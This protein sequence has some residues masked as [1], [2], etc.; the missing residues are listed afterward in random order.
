MD[1]EFDLSDAIERLGNAENLDLDHER[2]PSNEDP[3]T[4]LEGAVEAVADQ[5]DAITIPEVFASYCS[6]LKHSGTIPS[7]VMN[8]LLDS[9]S[10]GLQAEFDS[11]YSD[12]S[13][14]NR[15]TFDTHKKALEMYA[16]LLHWAVKVAEKVKGSD[17]DDRIS[18]VVAPKTRR[19]R[20]AKAA[21]SG[22][23]GGRTG[24]KKQTGSEEWNWMGQI[25]QV[26]ALISKLMSRLQTQRLWTTTAE[27]DK[28][29]G[30][31]TRPAYHVAENEQ[32]MKAE[33][34]KL[35]V[36][37]V[38]CLAVKHQGHS[39]AAQI[40]IMQRL[41]YY[42]HLAEPMAHCLSVLSKEFDHNQLGD[43]ILREVSHKDFRGQ[44]QKQTKSFSKFL[45]KIAEVSPRM[46]L[47]QMSLLVNHLDTDVANIRIAM[48]EVIGFLIRDLDASLDAGASEDG[49]MDSKQI[50][51]QIKGLYEMLLERMLDTNAP[52]RSKVLG[53]LT[54]L[55]KMKRKFPKQRL[56]ATKVAIVALEDKMPSVRKAAIVLVIEL[57][58]THPYGFV[59]GGPLELEHFE[60]EYH[61]IKTQLAE[62][63]AK[64][65]NA[66]ANPEDSQDQEDQEE[67]RTQKKRSDDEDEDEMDVDEDEQP[68]DEEKE[69]EDESEGED[70]DQAEEDTSMAGSKP[71]KAKKSKLKPRK[72]QINVVQMSAEAAIAHLEGRIAEQ[73]R[74]QKKFYVE[75]LNFIRQLDAATEIVLKLLGS[76]NKAEVLEGIHFFEV[77]HEYKL[78]YTEEGLRQMM[79]LIWSKD[80]SVTTSEDGTEQLKGIRSRLLECYRNLYFVVHAGEEAQSQ[81]NRIARNMIELTYGAT[82]AE[83]TSLEE[84]IRVMIEDRQI[85]PDVVNKLWQIFGKDRQLPK[86]QRRG[87]IIIIGMMALAKRSVLADRVETMLKVGLGALGKADLTLA[88]YTCVALQRLNGSAKKVKGSLHNKTLRLP[89]DNAVF[90]KLQEVI[91]R[92][93]RSKEWFGV[94]EQAINTIY[95][96]GEHPDRLC[97]DIIK[98]LTF[99]AFTPRN[100]T[101][102]AEQTQA[103]GDPDA[104][105]QDH[106]EDVSQTSDQPP[107]QAGKDDSLGDAFEL[108]QLL[109]VVGHIAIKHIAFLEIVER[110][111]KRQKDEKQAAEKAARG[112]HNTNKD[113]EELDQVAGNAEDEIGDRVQEI[114]EHELLE[115]GSLLALF[116][117]MLVHICGSPH[118]FKN[119]TLRAAATLSLSK[120]LCVSSSFCENNHRLLFKILET[121]KNASIRS[122][123]VIGLGDVA[124]SF[125]SIID[126]NSNELYKGLSDKDPV[127]KKNTLMVLTHLILNGMVKVK[128]Q[129]GE[130]AKCLQDEDPRIADL[131]K[132]FF[133]E[134]STKDNA[135]YNNLPDVISHLSTGEHA[136]DEDRFQSTMK[137]IFTFIEKEK[138][139]E[140]IVDKL[141]QRFRVA[142]E[143]RQWRDI[144][145]CLSLLPYKSE[146]SIKKLI[147]SLPAYQDKLHAEGV[148]DRFSEI[149]AKAR[150]PKVGVSKENGGGVDLQE[151]E[152][153][154]EQHKRQ[155]EDDQALEKRVEKKK[156][157]AKKRASRRNVRSKPAKVEE[158]DD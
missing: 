24:T 20:G 74:L 84:M 148:Y 63:E 82:L 117:P 156:A 103:N 86:Q 79:H 155:G 77:A 22:R 49:N 118:K 109:F 129:L 125:N 151:F 141:C 75:A 37:K 29:I 33:D 58:K 2:D 119:P 138:Q 149:L 55:C 12:I 78:T 87:A 21:G 126:E 123:V 81:V 83:L 14:D 6:L 139:A 47:K 61:S 142:D 116:G 76:T 41:Q 111:W 31:I 96:L 100:R 52:V 64:V 88:R 27:R 3:E 66:L 32:Y 53:V 150:Q 93:C 73:L 19:G 1:T 91:E 124:V 56:E 101:S 133:T 26:L 108:S 10:S 104:M 107:S 97:N 154:L 45:A 35:G 92:P 106:P 80:N 40:L 30:C 39:A 68:T 114:R 146:K 36:Y 102:G 70:D 90:R 136:V 122:N 145:F 144:A 85:H 28:F 13:N 99:R 23:A 140:N 95:A 134:L 98:K 15:Q 121:S 132:L 38:I 71:K 128:G 147:E 110:E 94:A 62:A 17:G 57:I 130:M 25:P 153:A 152:A 5:S 7:G 143:P 120:F 48:V 69:S 65:G 67:A 16:F 158:E 18:A 50:Q 43:E 157:A 135:I 8:K 115:G 137:Y 72:S 60:K 127:V 54:S 131:A 4:I 46:V 44:D 112:A 113:G 34:I 59:L 11:T 51:K 89:M 42:E 105:D 9:V